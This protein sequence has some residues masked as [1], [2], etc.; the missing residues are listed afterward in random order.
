ME[1]ICHP[2]YPHVSLEFEPDNQREFG[3]CPDCG[4]QT[5][6]VWGFVFRNNGAVAAYFVEWTPAHQERDATFDLIIG[7]WGERAHK[8]ERK[9]VS[10]AFRVLESGPSFMVQDAAGRKIGSSKLVSQALSRNEVIGH[11]IAEDVFEICDIVYL[12]DPRIAELRG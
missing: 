12:A 11:P 1:R 9:A 3:P 6:R 8:G 4:Q 5:K 7:N 2:D 10:L